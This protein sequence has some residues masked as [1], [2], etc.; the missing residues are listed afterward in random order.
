VSPEGR[1]RKELGAVVTGLTY[2]MTSLTVGLLVMIARGQQHETRDDVYIYTYPVAL[3]RAIAILSPLIGLLGVFVWQ[4]GPTRPTETFSIVIIVVFGG[5]ML[6][7]LMAYCYFSSL[8]IE[9]TAQT[10]TVRNC[11]RTRIFDFKDVVDTNLID[12]RSARGGNLQFVVYLR[13]G[14]KLRFYDTITD[15]D[16]LSELVSYRMAGPPG[17]QEATAA[18]LKDIADRTRNKRR[19]AWV[20]WIGI[21]VVALAVI[22]AKLA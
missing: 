22:A 15:F 10:L 17:G 13:D 9:V 8:R 7:G 11:F 1:A 4:R 20:L 12:G 16:D 21:A 18:K 2:L 3:T 19:E 14:G 5:G 6:A